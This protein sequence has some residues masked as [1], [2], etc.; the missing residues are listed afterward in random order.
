VLVGGG[1]TSAELLDIC[2]LAGINVVRT[3][4]ATETSGGCV[5]N[6]EPLEDVTLDFDEDSRVIVRGPMI[7][8][9]YRDGELIE[10][11]GWLS[12]DR[13]E[14]VDGQLQILGRI[15][16]LIKSGGKT[17]NLITIQ[18]LA[19]AHTAVA[20]AV[21]I[22]KA[23]SEYGT[24]ASLIYVGNITPDELKDSLKDNSATEG[25]HLEVKQVAV[26]PL[27]PNGKPDRQKIATL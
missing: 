5:Y 23:H 8:T 9:G 21:V 7:A 25:A 15:D 27:L 12:S 3:Y 10:D 24:V 19:L 16:D 26:I 13:G 4:G 22:G 2:R 18:E 20:E 6:G 17:I 14:I 11:S 1:A